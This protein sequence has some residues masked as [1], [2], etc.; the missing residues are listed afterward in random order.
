MNEEMKM[1]IALNSK[2]NQTLTNQCTL[3]K[4]IT[5]FALNVAPQ[6]GNAIAADA[7][8]ILKRTREVL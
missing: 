6:V 8:E 5:Q 1:L 4:M 2:L 7:Q 3:A